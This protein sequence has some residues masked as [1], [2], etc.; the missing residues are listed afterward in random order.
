MYCTKCEAEV[1]IA[2]KHCPKCGTDLLKFGATKSS[3]VQTKGKYSTGMKDLKKEIFGEV[4]D[5]IGHFKTAESFDPM[6]ASILKPLYS[7]LLN[8]LNARYESDQEIEKV[9]NDKIVPEVDRLSRQEDAL[10]F[11]LEIEKTIKSRLGENFFHHYEE[12][13]A[14]VLKVLRAG[15][16]A[17][18]LTKLLYQADLS[19][20]LFPFFKSAELACY[21]HTRRCYRSLKDHS[22]LKDIAKWLPSEE[23][24]FHIYNLPEWLENKYR[25][26]KIKKVV[27]GVLTE[28]KIDTAGSLATAIA[29]YMFGRTWD[30]KIHRVDLGETRSFPIENLLA[31]RGNDGEKEA[32]ANN[33]QKLQ[34]LRNKRVHENVEENR[35]IVDEVRNLSYECLKGLPVTF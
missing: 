2:D 29:L 28:D 31:A 10:K 25:K 14:D 1:T 12:K 21:F 22:Q 7:N 26:S 27:N 15:E 34:F 5:E 6:E 16:I 33:L 35:E 32:L 20:I 3:G 11:L 30:L 19:M 13:G 4:R 18:K 17:V 24:K 8:I 9:F 23:H